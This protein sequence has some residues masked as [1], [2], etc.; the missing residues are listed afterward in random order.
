[1]SP[2]SPS[3]ESDSGESESVPYVPRDRV[4][5]EKNEF[6]SFSWAPLLQMDAV[7]IVW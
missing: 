3:H 6:P 5:G 7:H 4:E 2:K 1:V